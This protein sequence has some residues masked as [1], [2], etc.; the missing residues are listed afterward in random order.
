M[1]Q[2]EEK[3]CAVGRAWLE[4]RRGGQKMCEHV[5]SDRMIVSGVS[6]TGRFCRSA[7]RVW[8]LQKRPLAGIMKILFEKRSG[9]W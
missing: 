7:I 3:A 9:K 4:G 2:C 6:R 1:G 5:L 8:P